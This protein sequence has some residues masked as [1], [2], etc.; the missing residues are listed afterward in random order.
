LGYPI[1]PPG[2]STSPPWMSWTPACMKPSPGLGEVDHVI[3]DCTLIPIDRIR[4]NEPYHSMKHRPHGM[5]VQ[6]VVRPDGTPLWFS[7]AMG[8]N[9]RHRPVLSD[10]ADPRSR[11]PHLLG[12]RRHVPYPLLSPPRAARPLAAVQPGRYQAEGPG[13]RAFAQLKSWRLLRRARCSTRRITTIVQAV[14][15][16]FTCGRS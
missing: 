3:A 15:T 13:E 10:P 1:L 11:G 4:V 6:F 16:L 2:E 12:C 9:P 8:A 7:C 5:N 14:H